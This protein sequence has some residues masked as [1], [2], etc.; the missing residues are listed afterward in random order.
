MTFYSFNP[1][2]ADANLAKHGVAFDAAEGFEWDLAI[3]KIDAR[4]AYG[5]VRCTAVSF[6]GDRLHVMVFTRRGETV[7]IISLRKA[8]MRETWHYEQF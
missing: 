2:K 6:I 1:N 7:H 4:F 3:E 8:N 5:E